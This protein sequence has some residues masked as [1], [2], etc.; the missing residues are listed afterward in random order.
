VKRAEKDGHLLT[1]EAHRAANQLRID[2]EKGG[3]HLPP[4]IY[5]LFLLTFCSTACKT[6]SSIEDKRINLS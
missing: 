3:I 2:F 6:F 4:G 5:T 1:K